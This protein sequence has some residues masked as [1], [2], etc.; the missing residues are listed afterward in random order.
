[1][2]EEEPESF[3]EEIREYSL[4]RDQFYP[5]HSFLQ[6]LIE[7]NYARQVSDNTYHI[8]WRYYGRMPMTVYLDGSLLKI[9]GDSI[10]SGRMKTDIEAETGRLKLSKLTKIL[11]ELDTSEA[12]GD[13]DN[14]DSEDSFQ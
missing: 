5:I 6:E 7:S 4:G 12:Q 2:D 8:G 1:M 9:A 14:E 13:M 10:S 11:Q 3:D